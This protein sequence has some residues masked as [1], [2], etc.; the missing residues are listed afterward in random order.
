M[1][2]GASECTT[3]LE[4]GFHLLPPYAQILNWMGQEQKWS[5][6]CSSL[7]FKNCCSSASVLQNDSCTSRESQQNAVTLNSFRSH[8]LV[9]NYCTAPS[10]WCTFQRKGRNALFIKSG[11]SMGSASSSRVPRAP[12]ALWGIYSHGELVTTKGNRGAISQ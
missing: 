7:L 10:G 4:R 6:F 1:Q 8:T 9:Q 12:W 5:C 2:K 3:G 11:N